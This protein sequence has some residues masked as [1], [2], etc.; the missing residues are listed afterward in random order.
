MTDAVEALGQDMDEHA[1]D[2]LV[3]GARSV[4]FR[5]EMLGDPFLCVLAG[6]VFKAVPWLIGELSRRLQEVA[7]RAEV[8]L[9]Q[10]EPAVGAV[11]LALA[12]LSGGAQIP[13]YK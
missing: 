1:A 10:D 7:P 13:Q 6:G 12:E 9:L 4:A 3:L 8:R 11:R 2:E 5:L